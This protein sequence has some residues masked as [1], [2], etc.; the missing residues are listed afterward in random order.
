M[1]ERIAVETLTL[2]DISDLFKQSLEIAFPRA[3]SAIANKMKKIKKAKV[4][5]YKWVQPYEIF[6]GAKLNFYCQRLP[7]VAEPIVSIGMTHRTSMGLI[8]VTVDTS[9][10]GIIKGIVRSAGW[11][12]WVRIYTGHFC[13]RYAQRIMKVETPTFKLGSEG[14]MFSDIAGVARVV[15][16]ISERVE[17]IEFQFKE[18]QAY[19]YRD[20]KC[21]IVYFKTVYANDMLRGD[22]LDFRE[23]WKEPISQL[24]E[25]FKRDS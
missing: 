12:K 20:I 25:L 9:N 3:K 2:N 13:E 7:N 14:I 4:S 11:D 16:T 24:Y 8:L 22:R 10:G 5:N 18:G 17:E 6:K 1:N 15:D 19:G 21:K 23:E